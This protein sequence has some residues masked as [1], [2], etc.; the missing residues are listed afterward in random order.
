MS[1]VVSASC[2][3]HSPA[4]IQCKSAQ[5]LLLHVHVPVF[6]ARAQPVSRRSALG[7]PRRLPI[8][9]DAHSPVG[10]ARHCALAGAG[11]PGHRHSPLE[12]IPPIRARYDAALRCARPRLP[13]DLCRVCST[14]TRSATTRNGLQRGPACEP[15][16][17]SCR[18]L[19]GPVQA[20]PGGMR[21]IAKLERQT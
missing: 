2:A 5:S 19:A 1:S 7:C 4:R 6:L 13:A 9:H 17:G 11:R 10:S 8:H 18:I 21:S 12:A 16:S 14:A 20:G 3:P 15:V